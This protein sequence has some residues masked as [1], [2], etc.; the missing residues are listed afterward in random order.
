[1]PVIGMSTFGMSEATYASQVMDR[2]WHLVLPSLLGAAVG[3]SVLSRYVRTQ[4]LEVI[5]QDYIRTAQAKG[6][7]QD[8]VYYKHG[9]CNI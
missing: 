4:M 6:L 9:F 1:M 3:I 5:H 7:K 2:V 8:I